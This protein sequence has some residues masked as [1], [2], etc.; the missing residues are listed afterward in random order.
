MSTMNDDYVNPFDNDDHRFLVVVNRHQQYSL[1]PTFAAQPAGWYTQFGPAK[2]NACI[3]YIE[4][5]W[6]DDVLF[7][8]AGGQ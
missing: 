6:R 3:D 1:W 4:R 7:P 5:N 2:R 8:N